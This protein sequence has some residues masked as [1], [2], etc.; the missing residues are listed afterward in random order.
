MNFIALRGTP[1]DIDPTVTDYAVFFAIVIFIELPP[2]LRLLSGLLMRVTKLETRQ[3]EREEE[4][5]RNLVHYH[6]GFF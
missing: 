2:L 1:N 4:G 3:K 5:F 6:L